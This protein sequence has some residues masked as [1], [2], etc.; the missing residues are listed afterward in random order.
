MQVITVHGIRRQNRWSE[1][2]QSLPEIS[3]FNLEI[4]EFDYGYFGFAKF[5]RKSKRK[6]IVE[7]FCNFYSANVKG[8]TPPSVIA[9]SFGTYVVLHAMKKYDVVKFD[10]VIFC[11]SILH[12]KTDFRELLQ[13]N[14]FK[15][16]KN[17]H[18]RL[19]WF[20]KH[21]RYLIGKVCGKAGQVGFLD[22]P[23]DKKNAIIN[24]D[25]YKEHSDYFLP[26]HMQ[27]NWI[28]FITANLQKFQ[29]NNF[30]LTATI[31]ERIYS[32]IESAKNDLQYSSA[33]FSARIDKKGNYFA[34]YLRSG[35]NNTPRAIDHVTF[36][37]SGDGIQNAEEMNFLPYD[38]ENNKMYFDIV[39]DYN[40]RKAFKIHLSDPLNPGNEIKYTCYFCWY[41]TMSLRN[42]DTDHW[43][44]HNTK[45]VEIRLN[46][47]HQLKHAKLFFIKD[48]RFVEELR[49]SVK[50]ELDSTYTY[51]LNYANSNNNDGVV[52]YYEGITGRTIYNYKKSRELEV[53]EGSNRK[54]VFT[55]CQA[56][57]SE[58]SNIYDIEYEVE[59]ANAASEEILLNRM[60]MFN[61]G[62]IVAKEKKGQ[63]VGYVESLI[64]NEKTFETFEEISNFPLHYNV[65]G[66]TLYVIFLAVDKNYRKLKIGSK[67]IEEI[68]IVAKKFKVSQVRLVA[69][70]TLVDFYKKLGFIEVRELPQFLSNKGYRSIL[71]EKKLK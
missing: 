62:F 67:L 35:V 23:A 60:S 26:L 70:G 64:W 36:S 10:K 31:I 20:L 19:E 52:F 6:D 66:S 16:L 53:N 22:V 45:D 42:G 12:S 37:V 71:M 43:S 69:K 30:I 29:F 51:Y 25:S 7:R 63:V 3:D 13:R 40:H 21:T 50:M 34:K 11:G 54:R 8:G 4:L 32:N 68:E 14:Q 57:E 9:H 28:P 48:N 24:A 15:Q 18:G 5:L 38:S 17:D 55:F 46:F 59:H 65:N 1:V 47:P 27:I 49:P 61:E 39:E 33:S 44:I 56:S 2:F 41:K 58:I